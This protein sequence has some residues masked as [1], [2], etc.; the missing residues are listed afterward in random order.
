MHAYVTLTLLDTLKL[1]RLP[2][3]IKQDP[4]WPCKQRNTAP[5]SVTGDDCRGQ[6][7]S[8]SYTKPKAVQG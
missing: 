8:K 5:N 4:G 3:V 1:K 7:L 2:Q 6:A